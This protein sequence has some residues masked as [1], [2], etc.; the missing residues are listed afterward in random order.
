VLAAAIGGGTYAMVNYYLR[1][2]NDE[3]LT[4]KM[5]SSSPL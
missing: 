4:Q 2:V 5:V 3:A 1:Q